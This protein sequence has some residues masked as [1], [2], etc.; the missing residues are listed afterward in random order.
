MQEIKNAAE[1]VTAAA[2]TTLPPESVSIN[3]EAAGT[4]S[5]NQ[6]KKL[7]KREAYVKLAKLILITIVNPDHPY[8]K[9]LRLFLIFLLQL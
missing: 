6:L 9:P 4:I 5:K 7:K 2:P 1:A 3:G 8:L